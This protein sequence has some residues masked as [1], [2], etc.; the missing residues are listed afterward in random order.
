VGQ[1]D[2]AFTFLDN[3][4]V[5]QLFCN[6]RGSLLPMVSAVKYTFTDAFP[7]PIDKRLK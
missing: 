3:T 6:N 1:L 5:A 2:A 4:L 7:G